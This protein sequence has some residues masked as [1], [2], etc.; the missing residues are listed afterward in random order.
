M[1]AVDA[2]RLART[3]SQSDA[4][5]EWGSVEFLRV[6]Q[7]LK[8]PVS[9]AV[10]EILEVWFDQLRRWLSR[11]ACGFDSRTQHRFLS[12]ARSGTGDG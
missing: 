10:L 9:E 11:V 8:D 3:S 1:D 12:F 2:E 7:E 6:E 4:V 5:A